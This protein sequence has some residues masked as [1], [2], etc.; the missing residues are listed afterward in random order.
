V[1]GAVAPAS[2]V[3]ATLRQGCARFVRGLRRRVAPGSAERAVSDTPMRHLLAGPPLAVAER[4]ARDLLL[5]MLSGKQ[6]REFELC[7]Y[8]S[9]EAPG[10]G[11]FW[12]LPWRS[13]NVVEPVTGDCYCGMPEGRLPVYDLM[14]AQKLL[15]ENDPQH[16]FSVANRHP[17]F[18]LHPRNT[19][20]AVSTR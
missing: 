18:A 16:F 12:I 17:N 20:P 5:R 15:L 14:L 2:G 13:L 8:F 6:R 9:V 11:R 1:I 19:R 7:G 3:V 10:R 4:R